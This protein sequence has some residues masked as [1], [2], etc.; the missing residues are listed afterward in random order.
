[1]K[2]CGLEYRIRKGYTLKGGHFCEFPALLLRLIKHITGNIWDSINRHTG[3]IVSQVHIDKYFNEFD[4]YFTYN[5][6][7]T[8]PASSISVYIPETNKLYNLFVLIHA[9]TGKIDYCNQIRVFLNKQVYTIAN[10]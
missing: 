9:L 1:M 3:K 8:D 2:C 6:H 4:C 5:R 7:V 10:K